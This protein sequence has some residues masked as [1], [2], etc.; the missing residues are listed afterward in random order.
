MRILVIAL[1]WF[2]ATVAASK[3]AAQTPHDYRAVIDS[4][5]NMR[6]EFALEYEV[7]NNRELPFYFEM[8]VP[9]G[10]CKAI[11]APAKF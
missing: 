4:A 7:S 9:L 6:V 1:G 8:G 5:V 10:H 2:L 11:V 3:L